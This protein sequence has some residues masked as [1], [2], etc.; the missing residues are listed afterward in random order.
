MLRRSCDRTQPPKSGA[1]GLQLAG[2]AVGGLDAS[3]EAGYDDQ[4]GKSAQ[5]HW[6]PTIRVFTPEPLELPVRMRYD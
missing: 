5:L 3:S 1:V 2:A 4:A 6:K